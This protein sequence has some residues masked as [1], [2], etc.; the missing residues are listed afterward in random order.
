MSMLSG[1]GL[2]GVRTVVRERRERTAGHIASPMAW[3]SPVHFAPV[4]EI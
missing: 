3:I 4:F 2:Q 1:G